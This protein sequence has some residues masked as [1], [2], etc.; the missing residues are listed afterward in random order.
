MV[1]YHFLSDWELEGFEKFVDFKMPFDICSFCIELIS[2]FTISQR[3]V[4]SLNVGIKVDGDLIN[5]MEIMIIWREMIEFFG[6]KKS[7]TY[8]QLVTKQ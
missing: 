3:E 7:T 4:F 8:W 2:K 6:E 1:K 5:C